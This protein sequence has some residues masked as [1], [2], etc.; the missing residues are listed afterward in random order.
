MRRELR[1]FCVFKNRA[2]NLLYFVSVYCSIGLVV[3][4]MISPEF[5]TVDVG[6]EPLNPY[7]FFRIVVF[8]IIVR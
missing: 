6:S 1:E 8:F 4:K 7:V 3:I 2:C 5:P